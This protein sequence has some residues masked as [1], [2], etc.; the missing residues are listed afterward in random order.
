ML[1]M[2]IVIM[3][4]LPIV[5]DLAGAGVGD[6]I[7]KMVTHPILMPAMLIGIAVYAVEVIM[8]L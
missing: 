3:F 2:L 4:V 7:F 6:G 8:G 5:L 1:V